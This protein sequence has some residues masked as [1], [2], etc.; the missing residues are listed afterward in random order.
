LKPSLQ[1]FGRALWSNSLLQIF[2]HFEGGKIERM[3]GAEISEQITKI[4][5]ANFPINN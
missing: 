5:A 4:L 1:F 2:I 3:F